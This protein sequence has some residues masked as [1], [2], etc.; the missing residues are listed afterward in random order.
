MLYRD[1]VDSCFITDTVTFPFCL[2]SF[3]VRGSVV[4]ASSY[5]H[6]IQQ[7]PDLFSFIYRYDVNMNDESMLFARKSIPITLKYKELIYC[8]ITI[9]IQ[10]KPKTRDGRW[11]YEVLT[12][13]LNFVNFEEKKI[14]G[15]KK[16]KLLVTLQLFFLVVQHEISLD[17]QRW[18][19]SSVFGFSYRCLEEQEKPWRVLGSEIYLLLKPSLKIT[20][21]PENQHGN[22][23]E[24][25]LWFPA[26]SSSEVIV[27]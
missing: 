1:Y 14:V 4:V 25:E 2:Q 12:H 23:E 16:D 22:P 20:S 27:F 26:H 24:T 21:H 15:L 3:S 10:G 11:F 5:F 7:Q 9:V 6:C 18:I 13:Y 17:S 8:R 19:D